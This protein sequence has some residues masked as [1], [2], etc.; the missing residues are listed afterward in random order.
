MSVVVEEITLPDATIESLYSIFQQCDGRPTKRRKTTKR[1]A[2]SLTQEN[3]VSTAGVPL[4]YIPL[5]RLTMRIKPSNTNMNKCQRPYDPD[6]STSRVPILIDVRNVH[7]LD[8]DLD[9]APQPDP[10][11]DGPGRM[12]LELSSLDE[13]ELLI[14]PCEDLQLFDL[15]GQLQA[16]S[17]LAHVD[18]FAKK[19]PTAC[20]QAHLCALPDGAG[21]SLETVVLWKDSIEVPDS[22]RL[23]VADLE[24]FTKYVRQEKCVRPSADPR[25]YRESMLGT[26]QEWSPRDFYKNVHVPEVTDSSNIKCPDLKCK[27]F[28]FQQRAV[29]WLLQREGREV[30]PNGEIMRM[31][32]LPKIIFSWF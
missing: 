17:K 26:P 22:N 23:G 3:G 2:R 7:F 21:F 30:G 18:K 11:D 9:N 15:L 14:Y 25:E 5:A 19:V 28:P 1:G 6:L 4:S 13:R 10:A 31:G 29:H 16:A 20:Y 27:L 32:E 24:A 12:E 8:E